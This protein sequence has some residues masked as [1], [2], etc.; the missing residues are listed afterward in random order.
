M[1]LC[2]GRQRE[3]RWDV[4]YVISCGDSGAEIANAPTSASLWALGIS[5][6][7]VSSHNLVSSHRQ[8]AWWW[9]EETDLRTRVELVRAHCAVYIAACFRTPTRPYAG[10]YI[11]LLCVRSSVK[12][13]L[14]VIV[15]MFL[16]S[17]NGRYNKPLA[18]LM[19]SEPARHLE[20]LPAAHAHSIYPHR[21]SS[22]LPQAFLAGKTSSTVLRGEYIRNPVRKPAT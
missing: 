21:Y 14:I 8:S 20:G 18:L 9:W 19:R 3:G 15:L 11:I 16:H 2:R 12:P 6:E 13:G 1:L 17:T 5:A 22:S 7:D 10:R 4:P